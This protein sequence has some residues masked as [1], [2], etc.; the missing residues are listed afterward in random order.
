MSFIWI[1]LKGH[2]SE[3]SSFCFLYIQSW[4]VFALIL[5]KLI[6][7]NKHINFDLLENEDETIISL[8]GGLALSITYACSKCTTWTPL[9]LLP[10]S[11]RGIWWI[12]KRGWKYGIGMRL[13]KRGRLILF[14]LIFLRLSCLYLFYCRVWDGV[15]TV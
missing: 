15:E 9:P 1:C 6:N 8:P 10:A 12:I 7:I 3:I 13:L 14:W 11:E 5:H 4:K 2:P